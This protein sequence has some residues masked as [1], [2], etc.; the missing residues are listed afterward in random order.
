M[1]FNSILTDLLRFVN[2]SHTSSSY[3]YLPTL[4]SAIFLHY[5]LTFI[6]GSK[7]YEFYLN[8]LP[9]PVT[10]ILNS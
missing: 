4:Y 2:K 3:R 7:Q 6:F 8:L 1:D 5:L 9:I 10:P